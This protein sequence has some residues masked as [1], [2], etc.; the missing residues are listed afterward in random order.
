M[1][2]W[3]HQFAYEWFELAF[4]IEANRV[5]CALMVFGWFDLVCYW[6]D[7]HQWVVVVGWGWVMVGMMGWYG[8]GHNRFGLFLVDVGLRERERE[9]E[10]EMN[11][12]RCDVKNNKRW[13][14]RWVVKWYAKMDKILFRCKMGIFYETLM[15]ILLNTWCGFL[16]WKVPKSIND[17][18]S[19]ASKDG[20]LD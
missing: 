8:F 4:W 13:D 7:Q 11:S 19:W 14:V 20:W 5:F 3:E 16:F 12:V 6:V 2:G 18:G 9:R 17:K 15:W 10:R 1:C